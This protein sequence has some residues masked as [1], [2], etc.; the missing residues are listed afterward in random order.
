MAEL[1]ISLSL[2]VG[3]TLAEL[4]AFMD[5]FRPARDPGLTSSGGTETVR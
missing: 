4:W 5:F 3:M 1:C 2:R